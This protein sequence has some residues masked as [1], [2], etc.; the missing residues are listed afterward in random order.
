[1]V[2]LMNKKNKQILKNSDQCNFPHA[3]I[4]QDRMRNLEIIGH[5]KKMQDIFAIID[6]VADSDSTIMINGNSGTGKEVIARAIHRKSKRRNK[7]FVPINC[8]AIPENLLESE[9]FGHVKGAFT[10]ATVSKTGKFELA[11]GGTIFLDEIG[12]M[13]PDLQVKLLRVL[14][15]REFERVGGCKMVKIDL[16]VLAATHRNLEEEVKKGR[17]R[18]DLFYRLHVI[19]IMLPLLCERKTDIPLFISKFCKDFN[20]INNAEIMGV[21]DKAMELMLDY[22]WPG[23]VRELKNVIECIVVLKRKGKIMPD[24]L[25][26]KIRGRGK[27][28]YIPIPEI[29]LV[30][31]GISLNSAVNE[32]EKALIFQSLEKTMWV[33][34]KAAKLLQ[35]N[36]TTLVEKIKRHRITP[37]QFESCAVYKV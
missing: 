3:D 23:N 4:S 8:G 21:S 26:D 15:E 10:G 9:L 16:R 7:P 30:K 27:N 31:E 11:D 17:F 13:S 12:D 29:Q 6:K 1:M 35:V 20:K 25:P 14:E 24:D 22:P 2:D 28:D 18:E 37:Q 32:F 19:P 36:R 5:S 34:N 33:K